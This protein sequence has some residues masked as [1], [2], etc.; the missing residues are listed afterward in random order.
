MK[1]SLGMKRFTIPE[2]PSWT[3]QIWQQFTYVG[4][5]FI[6]ILFLWMC[7]CQKNEP[8]CWECYV[9]SISN[10]PF[11]CEDPEKIETSAPENMQILC[12]EQERDQYLVENKRET[13]T[14]EKNCSGVLFFPI[15]TQSPVCEK[16]N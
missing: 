15:T 2:V 14:M 10:E 7:A 12:T 8:A 4:P 11:I 3:G 1:R 16:M 6:P 13:R 5:R 9:L